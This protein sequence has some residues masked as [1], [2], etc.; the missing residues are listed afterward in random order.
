MS[1]GC[2]DGVTADLEAAFGG[3]GGDLVEG[4]AVD[5]A[6]VLGGGGKQGVDAD[7]AALIQGE[8]NGCGIVAQHVGQEPAGGCEVAGHDAVR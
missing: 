1:L 8:A 6:A 4:V 2:P 7:P 5:G 3:V